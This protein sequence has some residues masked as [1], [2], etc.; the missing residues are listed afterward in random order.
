ATLRRVTFSVVPGPQ[1]GGC[2]DSAA[3][4]SE[5]PSSKGSSGPRVGALSLPEEGYERTTPEGSVGEEEHVEN[6]A[7]QLPDVALTGKCTRE[8]DEFGHS[9]TCWMPAA[10]RPSPRQHQRQRHVS[11]P[12]RLSTFASL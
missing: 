4:D 1:D 11:E 2:Y 9:D 7:R 5:T 10:V 8:C 3:E 12:P 6:D